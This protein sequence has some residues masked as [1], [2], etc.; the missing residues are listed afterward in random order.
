MIQALFAVLPV[1]FISYLGV[2]LSDRDI[3]PAHAGR[4]LGVFVLKIALPFLILHILAGAD[5]VDFAHGGFWLGAVG[6]QIVVYAVVYC[7]DRTVLHRGTGPAHIAALNA[8]SPNA[9]FVG[10]PLVVGLLPGN[11]EAVLIAVL[12]T[13]TANLIFIF[14]QIYFDMLAGYAAWSAGSGLSHLLRTFLVDNPLLLFAAFGMFLSISGIGLWQPL[15]SAVALIGYSAGPCMLLA[16]GL[17]LRGRFRM[18][19]RRRIRARRMIGQLWLVL[20]KLVLLPLFAWGIMSFCGTPPMWIGV[21]VLCLAT[22]SGM[23]SSVLA[24]VYSTVPDEAALTSVLTNGASL[25]TLTVAV[26][27]LTAFGYFS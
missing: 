26:Y 6:C 12:V 5:P 18:L 13:V 16:L 23:V 14:A 2:F 9:A 3:L 8:C 7:L 21:T 25:V 4:M 22:G 11:T 17:D 20:W 27:V 1:F 15:D 19:F 24:H 10:I